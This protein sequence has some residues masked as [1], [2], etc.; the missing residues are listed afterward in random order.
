MENEI[1]VGVVAQMY[2]EVSLES[3]IAVEQVRQLQ[4]KEQA[5]LEQVKTLEIRIENI[6]AKKSGK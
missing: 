3:R 5:L 2:F 6:E 1:P 4:A